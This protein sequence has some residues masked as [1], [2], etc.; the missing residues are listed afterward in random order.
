MVVDDEKGILHFVRVHL[1]SLGYDVI[2]TADSGEALNLLK[3]QKPDI[4]LLD[5]LMSPLNGFDILSQLRTFS[6]V[7]VIVFTGRH[8][9]GAKALKEGANGYIGKPFRP[10]DLTRK[11]ERT[12][13]EVS[14]SSVR[15]GACLERDK[16]K[17][18]RLGG[19]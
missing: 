18:A 14:P 12:L 5:I 3:S 2:T 6:R 13:G 9:I 8:D 17:K 10:E 1:T 4:V 15:D 19:G 16:P 7:P 11:I